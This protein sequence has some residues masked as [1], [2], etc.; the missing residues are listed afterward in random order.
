MINEI[1]SQVLPG[2]EGMHTD[3]R[4]CKC[5]CGCGETFFQRRVGR[6]RKYIDKTHKSRAAANRKKSASAPKSLIGDTVKELLDY[7]TEVYVPSPDSL[8][9]LDVNTADVLLE[10]FNAEIGHQ[11]VA[12]ALNDLFARYCS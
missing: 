3:L 4:E 12:D 7:L 11:R 2:F 8:S 1:H 6:V 9:W 5:E 10:V